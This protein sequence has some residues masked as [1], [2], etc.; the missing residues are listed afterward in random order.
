MIQRRLILLSKSPRRSQLLRE[1]GF[2]FEVKMKEV[3]ESYPDELPKTEVAEYIARKKV[4][5]GLEYLTDQNA[6]V[7]ADTIVLLDNV[8]YEKPKGKEDAVK[9][10]KELSGRTHTVITGVAIATRQGISSFS[11]HSRV[12]FA[13]LNNAEIDYYL[14]HWKPYDKAGSYGIQEW[15]GHCKIERIEGSYTN[16]MG[17]PMQR[18]YAALKEMEIVHQ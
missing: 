1:S 15:I 4:Q 16:I 14:A 9:M 8:I 10:L 7:T 2:E 11:D 18:L 12:S 6:V 3:D 17:L 13:R 5:A